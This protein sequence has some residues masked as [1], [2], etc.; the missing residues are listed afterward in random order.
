MYSEGGSLPPWSTG[1][2]SMHRTLT[3]T[4]LGLLLLP[5]AW[6]ERPVS[7][8]N[9]Q[10]PAP[11]FTVP[12]G[13]RVELAVRIPDSDPRFSL[14]N[15]TFDSQ[16][17]LLVSREGGAVLL[18]TEPDKDGVLQKVRPYC[19]QVKNCQGMCWVKD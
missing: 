9:R 3:V 18:C 17:R 4:A 13:F 15:M 12:D 10:Q 16:G 11:R 14:V 7:A 6:G 19:E 1:T 5:I 2:T 8:Q